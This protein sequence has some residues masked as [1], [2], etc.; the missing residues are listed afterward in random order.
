VPKQKR[1]DPLIEALKNNQSYIWT[2]PDGGN[3]ASM[4][5]V[6][7]HGQSLTF[8]PVEDSRQVQ[9]GDIVVVKWRGGGYIMHLVGEIRDDQ[10]LIINSLGKENGWVGGEDILGRVTQIIDPEPRP[11]VP[12]MLAQLENAYHHFV[13]YD[14]PAVDDQEILLS[15]AADMRWYAAQIGSEMWAKLPDLNRW[16]FEQHLWH[17]LR[18][19]KNAIDAEERKSM[20]TLIN[21]GKEHIGKIAEAMALFA[22]DYSETE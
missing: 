4:R 10:Y 21:H 8:S 16:S 18:Q 6:L 15:I 3:L 17:I 9:V 2:I 20:R 19:A 11:T 12:D 22:G 5:A 7:K 1:K 13:K 14:E